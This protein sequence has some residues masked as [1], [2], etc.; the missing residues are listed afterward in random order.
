MAYKIKLRA[1]FLLEYQ[2]ENVAAKSVLLDEQ[3]T[4]SFAKHVGLP[5]AE[6]YSTQHHRALPTSRLTPYW[7][8]FVSQPLPWMSLLFRIGQWILTLQ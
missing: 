6:H 3:N 8:I 5:F 1:G 7:Y 2:G 4:C